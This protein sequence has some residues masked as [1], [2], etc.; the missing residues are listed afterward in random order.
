M[1][2]KWHSYVS[3]RLVC[4]QPQSTVIETPVV[5][6]Y[7]QPSAIEAVQRSPRTPPRSPQQPQPTAEDVARERE[8]IERLHASNVIAG[9]LL[10]AHLGIVRP[11][12]YIG[13]RAP[14]PVPSLP[15]I[16]HSHQPP[17]FLM[18][19]RSDRIIDEA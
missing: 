17:P 3:F 18:I 2:E 14:R 15:S 5:S 10:I 12:L 4:V 13:T 7:S 16:P 8:R 11:P 1:C 19:D 9:R 6:M